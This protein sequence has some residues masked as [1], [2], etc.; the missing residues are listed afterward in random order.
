M[1]ILHVT[2][3]L[4]GGV[5]KALA[6]ISPALPDVVEQTFVL[7]EPPRDRRHIEAIEATGAKIVVALH[8]D[9]VAELAREADIVQFEYWNHPRMFVCLARCDFPAMRSVFWSHISGL[10]R[11]LI[12]P[13]LMQQAQRFVFT[14]D[15]SLSIPWVPALRAEAP[16][17]FG[18]INSGFGFP[19][20]ARRRSN[21]VPTIAYLGTVDFIKMHPG[22]FDAVDRLDGDDI[23]VSV[24]G[25]ASDAV[26]MRA[27][28]M[29]YPER[30]R[31]RGATVDPV[32]ALAEADIFFYPLQP[33]HFGTAENALVEAMSLGL[34]PVVLDNP[35]ERAII[36]DGENG[37]VAQ[38]IRECASSLQMLL[39]EADRREEMARNAMRH[40]ADN[41][42]P[43]QSALEFMIVWLGLI[44]EPAKS[45]DFCAAI[46]DTAAD[47]FLSTQTLP[48][49]A[50][51]PPTWQAGERAA[52]GTLAH[53]ESVF[54]GDATLARL[55]QSGAAAGWERRPV[56]PQRVRA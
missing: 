50:W 49:A 6:A 53:F 48:G 45:Y 46:G 56:A 27:R 4:G 24:W 1:R 2:P 10:S 52:K 37:I 22:F 19:G 36:R 21:G 44:N 34:V 11:P 23:H 32:S 8:V 5:G 12:Q 40:V 7:L 18:V 17:K 55:R 20:A 51:V 26:T 30:I 25:E 31:F 28:G 3:H 13:D 14:T 47:W 54:V 15:A 39:S 16:R 35:A 42:T 38:S 9:R 29:R 41:L 43:A 33:D